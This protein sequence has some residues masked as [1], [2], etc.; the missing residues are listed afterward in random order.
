MKVQADNTMFSSSHKYTKIKEGDRID[1]ITIKITT[2]P[3]IDHLVE[4]ETETHPTEV[5]EILVEIIDKIIEEDHEIILGMITDEIIK[6]MTIDQTM[7]EDNDK[8]IKV[9]VEIVTGVVIEI[10]QERTMCE[11]EILVEIGVK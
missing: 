4:T 1:V 7:T 8:E 6:E 11:I 5:E 10:G 9:V 2:G 3:E